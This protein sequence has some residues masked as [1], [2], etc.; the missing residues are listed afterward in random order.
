LRARPFTT[1]VA[2]VAFVLASLL[3]FSILTSH[4]ASAQIAPAF[5]NSPSAVPAPLSA[6]TAPGAAE[7]LRNQIAARAVQWYGNTPYEWG[8]VKLD[9]PGAGYRQDCSGFVSYAWGLAQPGPV[10]SQFRDYAARIPFT[11]LEL[12]D[13][14]N[15]EGI[16]EDGHMILFWHWAD[17][18]HTRFWALEMSGRFTD[19]DGT[20]S[21]AVLNLYRVEGCTADGTGCRI[22]RVFNWNTFR[23]LDFTDGTVYYAQRYAKLLQ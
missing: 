5:S 20:N 23:L 8:G 17:D 4:I 12:G 1:W 13:A 18:S 22:R 11:T 7:Q 16:S 14:V 6:N 19:D 21:N 9:G 3:G 15:N 2:L 10:T